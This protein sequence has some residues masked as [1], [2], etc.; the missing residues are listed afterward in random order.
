MTRCKC[1]ASLAGNVCSICGL[2]PELC[3]CSVIEREEEKIKIF[4]EKR[5]FGKRMTI[6]DGIKDNPKK[7]LS[8]L[9]SKL[10]CGGTYKNGKLELQGDHKQRIKDLLIELGYKE[11][12]IEII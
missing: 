7:T 8:Y 9:K 2:P 4:V 1:G 3:T 6:I 11:G 5:R 10:A 12:Q